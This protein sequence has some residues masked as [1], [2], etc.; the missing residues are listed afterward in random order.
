MAAFLMSLRSQRSA[1]APVDYLLTLRVG[2][3]TDLTALLAKVGDGHLEMREL[4]AVAT[5]KEGIS[6]NATYRARLCDGASA[7]DLVKA[8]NRLEGVQSVQMERRGW[9][10]E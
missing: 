7:D 5:A 3:G 8:L 2:I 1:E 9:D 6:L 4:L 10:D